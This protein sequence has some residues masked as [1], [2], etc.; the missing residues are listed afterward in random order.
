MDNGTFRIFFYSYLLY[1]EVSQSAVA[2]MMLLTPARQSKLLIFHCRLLE[3]I[4][5]TSKNGNENGFLFASNPKIGDISSFK[6]A[7]VQCRLFCIQGDLASTN[8]P[9]RNAAT[10]LM[11]TCHRQLGPDLAAMIRNNVKPALMTS[12]EEA[13]KKNPKTQVGHFITTV[14]HFLICLLS[15]SNGL[16]AT[17]QA[18]KNTFSLPTATYVYCSCKGKLW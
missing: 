2:S 6:S 3:V 7:R 9:V 8:A 5:Y 13:F 1:S 15:I 18:L 16:Y 4:N 17:S 14:P 12:L 11:A 10:H